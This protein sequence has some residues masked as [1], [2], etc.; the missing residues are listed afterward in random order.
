[1]LSVRNEQ[2]RA[3]FVPVR[4]EHEVVDQQLAAVLEEVEQADRAFLPL[5]HVLLVDLDHRQP[6]PL[7]VHR[8][9]LPGELL[10]GLQQ[11]Q[12]G[13]EPFSL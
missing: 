7:G 9:P 1:M 12:A 10:L 8:V 11:P 13:G 6:A 4:I 5:E 2:R 3:A